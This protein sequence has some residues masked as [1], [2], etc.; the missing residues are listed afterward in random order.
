[1]TTAL[2]RWLSH[3]I[4]SYADTCCR[5]GTAHSG[6][7]VEA[8][9]SKLGWNAPGDRPYWVEPPRGQVQPQGEGRPRGSPKSICFAISSMSAVTNL[10]L[11]S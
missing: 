9:S 2:T 4:R 3:S 11:K 1:M 7:M 5:A 10:R 6:V 8:N